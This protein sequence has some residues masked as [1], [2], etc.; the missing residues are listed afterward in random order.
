MK[1][2]WLKTT[3]S[4]KELGENVKF[5]PL[6]AKMEQIHPHFRNINKFTHYSSRDHQPQRVFLLVHMGIRKGWTGQQ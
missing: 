3:H 2:K 1:K 5:H 4:E 6:S